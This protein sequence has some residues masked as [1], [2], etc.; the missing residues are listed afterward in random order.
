MSD[1]S[2]DAPCPLCGK[3]AE[4]G[5]VYGSDKR[6]SLRWYPGPPGFWANLATGMGGGE[7]VGGFGF[8]SGPYVEGVRCTRCRK[9]V[10]D[11]A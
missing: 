4:H 8:G 3:A 11:C 7:P 9:I 6:W 5:C 1:T 2:N 10:L